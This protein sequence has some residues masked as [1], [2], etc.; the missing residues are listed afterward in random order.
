MTDG[1][2]NPRLERGEVGERSTTKEVI[3]T[4]RLQPY[5]QNIYN[6]GYGGAQ[7]KGIL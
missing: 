4:D 3:F 6:E 5:K 1:I 7:G 2:S